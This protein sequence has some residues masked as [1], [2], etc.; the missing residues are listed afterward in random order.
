M[1]ISRPMP[2]KLKIL[3]F[4]TSLG[5]NGIPKFIALYWSLIRNLHD[6]FIFWVL[7]D[8]DDAYECLLKINMPNNRL[9]N[10]KHFELTD[11]ELFAVKN[12]RDVFEYNCTLRPI[13]ILYILRNNPNIDFLTYMDTDLY[14]FSDPLILYQQF[15]DNKCSILLSEHR[16]SLHTLMSGVDPNQS[17][18]Y[19]AG[20]IAFKN[21]NDAFQALI[22]W[23]A[24]CIKWCKRFYEDGKFGE[25]KYLDYFPHKFTGAFVLDNIGSNVGPWNIRNYHVSRD[26][27]NRVFVNESQLIF[28]HFHALQIAGEKS[29]KVVEEIG[30]NVIQLTNPNYLLRKNDVNYI[31]KSYVFELKQA[32][33]LALSSHHKIPPKFVQAQ[34]F[35]FKKIS[36][37]TQQFLKQLF[38]KIR[39][40]ILALI[41]YLSR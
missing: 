10:I 30:A 20:W 31:Y 19:N 12:E 25:Q 11:P 39:A 8:G 17:G 33:N 38:L 5:I 3:N 40:R 18:K 23:R 36:F 21:N 41:I 15:I 28:Y 29:F 27:I 6:P 26:F 24:E 37:L 7:C 1:K 34:Q 4:C 14:F 22:W 16:Y 2:E 9:V 32:L 13:W 35:S